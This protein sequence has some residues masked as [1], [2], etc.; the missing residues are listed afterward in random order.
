[1]FAMAQ[2]KSNS[3]SDGRFGR[4]DEVCF[5]SVIGFAAVDHCPA[6]FNRVG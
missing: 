2:L 3:L 5:Y 4:A 6:T 1:M